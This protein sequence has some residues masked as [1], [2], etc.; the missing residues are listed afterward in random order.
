MAAPQMSHPSWQP[1][2]QIVKAERFRGKA[3]I[4]PGAE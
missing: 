3:L 2:V 1:K 4:V